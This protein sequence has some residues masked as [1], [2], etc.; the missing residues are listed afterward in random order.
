[1]LREG[2]ATNNATSQ[3]RNVA[4]SQLSSQ[5]GRAAETARVVAQSLHEAGRS[6][7]Q[8]N[9]GMVGQYAHQA[10]QQ[11][12]GLSRAIDQ[13][14]PDELLAEA[15]AF[16]R[17]QPAL[18]LGLAFAGGLLAARFLKSSGRGASLGDRLSEAYSTASPDG[19]TDGAP[20]IDSSL[21]SEPMAERT[22][23]W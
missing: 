14:Q 17:R 6:L 8:G 22:G 16:A 21:P 4:M 15:E 1:M 5:K 9:Q 19:A 11:L 20:S 3:A 13:K 10:A 12:E 2:E 23:G 18:F 7:E